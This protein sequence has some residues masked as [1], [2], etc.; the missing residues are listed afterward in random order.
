MPSYSGNPNLAAQ[1]GVF[2]MWHIQKEF[3]S[4]GNSRILIND[5]VVDTRS[6]DELLESF[7]TKANLLPL[8]NDKERF[9]YHISI[10]SDN[11]KLIY[12]FIKNAG[13]DARRLFP[14]YYGIVRAIKEEELICP[15]KRIN[16]GQR[17]KIV[18]YY[19]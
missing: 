1:K 15:T 8:Q 2:T 19:E 14:G 12:E 17:I 6:F 7:L 16:N 4:D 18:K 9:L 10:P 11:N 3:R 5:D 13:Y